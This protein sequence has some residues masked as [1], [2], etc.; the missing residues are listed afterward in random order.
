MNK[1]LFNIIGILLLSMVAFSFTA[2]SEDDED[3]A[4]KSSKL[5]GR[6]EDSY[7]DMWEFKANGTG[8]FYEYYDTYDEERE[9]FTYEYSDKTGKL[10]LD[11]GGDVE[12]TSIQFINKD[13]FRWYW[14]DEDYCLMIRK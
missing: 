12:Y 4:A 9:P 1:K 5:V 8:I 13:S 7:G 3:N 6:W 11:W 14:D 2:C 10:I